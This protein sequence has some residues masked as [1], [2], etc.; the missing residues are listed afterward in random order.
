MRKN[1]V[2]LFF[3][4]QGG[5]KGLQEQL[6]VGKVLGQGGKLVHWGAEG[7]GARTAATRLLGATGPNDVRT[8]STAGMVHGCSN[9]A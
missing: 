3:R 6:R 4:S 7:R 8:I 1:T 9:V 2:L 5:N